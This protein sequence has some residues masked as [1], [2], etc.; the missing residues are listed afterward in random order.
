MRQ[1]E[2]RVRIEGIVS[3]IDINETSFTRNGQLKEAIGG[4]ITIRVK[5]TISGEEKV[6]EVPVHCFAAKTTNKGTPNPAYE[7]ISKVAKEYTSIAACGSEEEADCIRVTSG[8][9]RMNEY[10]SQTGN[11]VSFPRVNNSFFQKVRKDE[12]NPEATFSAQFVVTSKTE[13]VDQNGD[14]TG[15]YIVTGALPQYG[16]LIDLIK[17]YCESDGVINA[18]STYWEIG[19]TVQAHGKLNFSSK[20]ETITESSDFGEAISRQRTISVSEL[21]ITGGSQEPLGDELGYSNEEIR[22]GLVRRK[23]RLEELKNKAMSKSSANRIETPK[24][25]AGFDDLGF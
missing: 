6:L 15:R 25:N 2:N 12:L 4:K 23:A 17:F 11:F 1:A 3:E 14:L 24:K 8:D 19:D 21:I 20:T 16:G 18:V 13:E 5:Q 7:S 9:I 10:Y 22:E